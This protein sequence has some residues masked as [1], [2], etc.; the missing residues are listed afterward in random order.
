MCRQRSLPPD[1]L[2]RADTTFEAA[3]RIA[4]R[5]AIRRATSERAVKLRR[6]APFKDGDPLQVAPRDFLNCLFTAHLAVAQRN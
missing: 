3:D 1:S 4:V 5:A 2:D 6:G